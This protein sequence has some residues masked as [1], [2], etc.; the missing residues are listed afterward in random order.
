MQGGGGS[1]STGKSRAL[2]PNVILNNER[3]EAQS[4]NVKQNCHAELDSAS[5]QHCVLSVTLARF[6]NRLARLAKNGTAKSV[7]FALCLRS[8]AQFGMTLKE[9][10]LVC[11]FTMA[12]ILLSLTI[13]GVVA[14]ITLP[15]L[16]G[17]INERTWNTQRKALY[18]RLSQ[19]VALMPSLNGYGT[20][21]E[22]TDSAGTTSIEDNAAETFITSGLSKVL[23]INNI[24]DNEHLEDCGIPKKI[25]DFSGSVINQIPST[26][27]SLNSMFAGSYINGCGTSFSYSQIDTKAAA[28]E[29]ANGESILIYYNPN[30]QPSYNEEE[31]GS[32]SYYVQPKLCANLVYDLNGTKGPNTIGKDMGFMSVMYPTDPVVAA[33]LVTKVIASNQYDASAACNAVEDSRVANIKE[34]MSIFYNRKLLNEQYLWSQRSYT[35]WSS[36]IMIGGRALAMDM[37]VGRP[38]QQK[39]EVEFSVICVKR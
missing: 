8:L 26:L 3:T 13:I 17:N 15:S 32:G 20:L 23:K 39:R 33:P 27:V 19:A 5:I 30:C 25:T 16:T 18:A 36:G 2:D 31:I 9:M 34:L 4:E 12:E 6:R 29:T 22:T 24:C 10:T 11:A 14:A 38:Y 35:A 1:R 28:F 37:S 7:V 21:K